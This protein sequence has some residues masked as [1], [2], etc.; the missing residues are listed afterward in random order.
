MER[1]NMESKFQKT[2]VIYYSYSGN[3]KLLAKRIANDLKAD[4][5]QIEEYKKRTALTI[6]LD[7]FLGRSPEIIPLK[8]SLSEYN[9]IIFLAPLWNAKI[10]NPLK[11]FLL[12]EK[13]NIKKYSFVTLCGG[14]GKTDQLKKVKAQLLSILE[15]SPDHIWELDVSD[16]FPEG[17]KKKITKISGY[18]ITSE[19]L[20]HRF[21]P[22]LSELTRTLNAWSKRGGQYSNRPSPQI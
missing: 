18:K 2:A 16:L 21:K 20:D 11:S 9:H 13:N 5:F 8:V 3:N 6:F 19:D 1:K 14:Y 12:K 10:A 4:L 22:R 17:D 15:R 7:V